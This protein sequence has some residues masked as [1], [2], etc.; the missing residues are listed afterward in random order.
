MFAD[1]AFELIKELERSSQTIPP[2]DV[3]KSVYIIFIIF[4]QCSNMHYR[5][6]EYVK[7][8]R[9]SKQFLK[10]TVH[11]RKLNCILIVLHLKFEMFHL[12]LIILPL[13]I[14]LCGHY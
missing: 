2:F 5:M 4:E 7:Y 6:M 8:W 14:A 10:R 1:K 12:A 11:K 3:S 9:K 13:V